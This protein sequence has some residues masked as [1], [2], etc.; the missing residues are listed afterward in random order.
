MNSYIKN[1]TTKVSD[2]FAYS[3]TKFFRLI[4]DSFFF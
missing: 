1:T 4:A 3:M 2:V